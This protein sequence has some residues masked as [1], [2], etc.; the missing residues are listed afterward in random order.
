[1][2]RELT[3]TSKLMIFLVIQR[4][5]N[6]PKNK[7]MRNPEEV[8]RLAKMSKLRFVIWEMAVGHTI[9]SPLRF[10]PGNTDLQKSLLEQTTIPLLIF[11]VLH[12][13]FLKW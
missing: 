6:R 1:V 8:Q 11:G 13:Q 9:T 3:R 12:A 7:K 4:A 10:R 5:N 2:L